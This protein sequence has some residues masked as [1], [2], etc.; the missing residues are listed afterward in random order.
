MV[1]FMIDDALGRPLQVPLLHTGATFTRAAA[2]LLSTI[3][4]AQKEVRQCEWLFP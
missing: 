2:P 1:L 4:L 3:Q